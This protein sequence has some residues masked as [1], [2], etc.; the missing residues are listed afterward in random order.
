MPHL[1]RMS[2]NR[3]IQVL[4]TR[5]VIAATFGAVLMFVLATG[6]TRSEAQSLSPAK[7][8]FI[9]AQVKAAIDVYFAHWS[10]V[11]HADVDKAFA[12]Y[13]QQAYTT[14]DRRSFDLATMRFFAVMHNGH[15]AFSDSW[16]TATYGQR[17]GF[18]ARRIDGKW[19]V[20]TSERP[21]IPAGAAIVSIDRQ[22]IDEFFE[23]SRLY[24]AGS[25]EREQMLDLF[26]YAVLFPQR[27]VVHLSDGRDVAVVRS[28][29]AR[30]AGSDTEARDLPGS[31]GYIAIHSF[32]EGKYESQAI[33][34]V[35]RFRNARAIIVDVRG[36]GGGVTPTDLVM[37]LMNR[38]VQYLAESSPITVAYYKAD[39][40][41]I[42]PKEY[43]SS[44]D[45]AP[46]LAGG[47]LSWQLPVYAPRSDAYE[48]KVIILVDGGCAS[49]CDDFV[50][51]FKLA[52]RATLIGETTY[53]S[54]GQPYFWRSEDGFAFHVSAKRL[55]FP[56]GSPFE[57][58]GVAPDIEVVPTASDLRSG[59]DPVLERAVLLATR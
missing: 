43:D 16:L 45:L 53:G 47:T 36:N 50:V 3:S 49:A 26:K 22:P 51:P 33:D 20:M 28:E 44:L 25:S 40:S 34:A 55:Q 13:I 56:D 48:G 5:C 4:T 58:V 57:G 39:A 8:A 46:P 52:H 17:I 31:I 30:P 9:A 24:I 41:F 12:D 7:R 37:S 42:S 27:F 1:D 35:K 10:T 11:N 23:Q 14:D 18:Y 54:A 59:K 2:A 6:L 38:P 32:L 29:P 21:E 15:T 19:L